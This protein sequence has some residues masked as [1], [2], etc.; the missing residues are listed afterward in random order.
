MYCRNLPII[1]NKLLNKFAPKVAG[2]KTS[3]YIS[4]L[5]FIFILG[6]ILVQKDG[7]GSGGFIFLIIFFIGFFLED[8]LNEGSQ[9]SRF[10]KSN[11]WFSRIDCI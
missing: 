1:K 6:I 9:R 4:S 8:S 3:Y 11:V 7:F 2:M 5:S 10:I